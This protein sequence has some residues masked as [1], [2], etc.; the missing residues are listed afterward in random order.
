MLRRTFVYLDKNVFKQL[1][2][3]IVRPHLEYGAPIWNP[4]TRKMINHIESV[5]RR[6]T[7]LIPGMFDLKYR[8][9]LESM[10][11]PTLQYRRYRG[12][13]IE[14]YKLSHNF[15]DEN[16]S[17]NLLNFQAMNKNRYNIRGHPFKINKL[18]FKTDIRKNYFKCRVA[19][20]W[21]NLP[22]YIATA[23]SRNSFKNQLDRL[24]ERDGIM[25]DPDVN[26]HETTSARRTRYETITETHIF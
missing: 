2:V 23:P 3:T 11:L 13:M 14:V 18:K 9:R 5:Q 1:F 20:Q 17:K 19:E 4:C 24:W 7:K 25:Y 21:N 26:I 6:A 15:Y 12:D 16:S 10:K 8:E 22:N